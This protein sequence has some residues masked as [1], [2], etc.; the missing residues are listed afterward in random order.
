MAAKEIADPNDR[1]QVRSAIGVLDRH[2]APRESIALRMQLFR[3]AAPAPGEDLAQFVQRIGELAES[4]QLGDQTEKLI[5]N[6]IA[7]KITDSEFRLRIL[8]EDLSLEAI[9]AEA[10]EKG[11][12]QS[13]FDQQLVATEGGIEIHWN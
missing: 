5:V 1:N 8:M 13:M 10:Y 11:I 6:Q 3:E 12:A 9:V 2:F 7:S 4:C